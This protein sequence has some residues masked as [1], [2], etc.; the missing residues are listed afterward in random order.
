MDNKETN[1]VVE[2]LAAETI[3]NRGVK[4]KIAAPRFMRWLKKTITIRL[5]SPYE[6]TMYRVAAYYLSTGIK[7]QDLTNITVEESLA[8]M[9]VHGKAITK[10]VACAILNGYWSGLLFTKPFAWYLR[11]HCKPQEL[12]ALT[13]AILIYGG[14]QDFTNTTRSVRLMKLTTP[15][16]GQQTK[17]S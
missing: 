8:L 13:T 4:V 2:R 15:R 5:R 3:L 11:W 9:A 6:G 17:E 12:F 1:E 14:T 10:A 16:T 7:E